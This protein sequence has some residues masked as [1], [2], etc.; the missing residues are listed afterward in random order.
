MFFTPVT[1]R[2]AYLS[3]PRP[4]DLRFERWLGQLASAD[5]RV[6]ADDKSYTLTVDLPGISKEQLEIVVEDNLLRLQTV[7]DAPRQYKLAYEF[8]QA[9]DSAGSEAKLES[10]VLTL[11]LAK[12]AVPN[13]AVQI[14]I[15]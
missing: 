14:N 3:T 4:W 11:K 15:T 8:T 12:Q 6:T 1:R 10:G 13:K 7:A 5:A 2:S 9:I